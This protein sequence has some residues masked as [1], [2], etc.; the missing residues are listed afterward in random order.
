[1]ASCR[2]EEISENIIGQNN[3]DDSDVKTVPFYSY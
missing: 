2:I 3:N 1:M